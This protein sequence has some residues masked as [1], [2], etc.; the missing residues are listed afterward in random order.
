VEEQLFDDV[1]GV[2][3]R[4]FALP[5][6]VKRTL[7]KRASPHFRGYEPAGVELTGGRP[8][9]REQFDTWSE[10]EA[11]PSQTGNLRLLGPNQF[12]DDATLPGYRALT[13]QWMQR[14]SDVAVELLEA[15]SLALELPPNYLS[16]KFGEPAQ[17]QSLIK[18]I[19][20]PPTPEN[21]QGVG[22]HQDR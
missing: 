20:Y 9:S 14:C 12:F 18:Y 21:G 15:L 13:M 11:D 16:A 8:D 6:D 7:D 10:G 2:V 22:L 3:K 17:R 4:A 5:D 1:F 19:H